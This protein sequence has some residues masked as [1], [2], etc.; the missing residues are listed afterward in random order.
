M[1]TCED[2]MNAGFIESKVYMVDAGDSGPANENGRDFRRRFCDQETSGGGWTVADQWLVLF[3][4]VLAVR[5]LFVPS[6]A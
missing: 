5:R 1:K 4:G 3:P 6:A 2:L